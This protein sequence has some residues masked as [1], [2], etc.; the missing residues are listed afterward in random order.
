MGSLD[1]A[2]GDSSTLTVRRMTADDVPALMDILK[3]SPEASQWSREG[4]LEQASSGA[5]WIAE[6]GGQVCGF[7][8]GRGVAD[9]FE[10]LNLAVARACRRGGVASRLVREGLDWSRTAG[11]RRAYLEVRASNAAAIAL[12]ARHGF[13]PCGRRERYY[14]DPVDDAIVLALDN[15]KTAL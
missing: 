10:I 6:R 11:A 9:E 15:Q 14:R 4:L 7:L 2:A 12:Y 8:A 13:H 3:N 1:D 5:V